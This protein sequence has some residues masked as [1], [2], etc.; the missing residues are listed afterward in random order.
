MRVQENTRRNERRN[1]GVP[2]VPSGADIVDALKQ[3]TSNENSRA[4]LRYSPILA[5]ATVCSGS[6]SQWIIGEVWPFS[7]RKSLVRTAEVL[8][9]APSRPRVKTYS[10]ESGYV[11]Q[12]AYR[13]QRRGADTTE[14]VFSATDNRHEWKRVSVSLADAAVRNWTDA[15]GR[16]LI[17]AER[18]AVAKLTLFEF[19]DRTAGLKAAQGAFLAPLADDIQR[20]LTTLGRL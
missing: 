14:F 17:A 16:E 13:G 18:Y 7:R 11:Y 8:S 19:F 9:G 6:R 5:V 3:L 20:H 2:T 4:S 1:G 15:S 12:Y 10:A